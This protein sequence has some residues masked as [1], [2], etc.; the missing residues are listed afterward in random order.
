[1]FFLLKLN[2]VN[3]MKRHI[4]NFATILNLLS[5]VIGIWFVLQY[6][7]FYGA[8]LIFLASFF[9]FTDGFLARQLNAYSDVGKSLDS[10]SDMISFGVL[11]GFL[12]FRLQTLS[13]GLGLGYEWI[14]D[15][16]LIEIMLLITPLIIPAFSAIR[17]ARFDNDTRQT[18]E[19]RGLPTPANAIFIAAWV[20]AYPAIHINFSWL[21]LPWVIFGISTLLAV[22]LITDIPMFSLKFKTFGLRENSLRYIFLGISLI[23]IIAFKIPGIMAII[24]LYIAISIF[25]NFIK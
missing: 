25:R 21:Y 6:N 14:P 4:P 22:L 18:V 12:I 3:S 19:F 11:P 9:D 7:P 23:A 2:P 15:L 10:L 17:L 8:L 16:T 20:Y 5:G 24:T 1:L 13:L